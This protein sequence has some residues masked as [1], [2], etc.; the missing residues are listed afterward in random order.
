MLVREVVVQ[1][2]T[3]ALLLASL[4]SHVMCPAVQ[5]PQ[6]QTSRI[7]HSRQALLALLVAVRPISLAPLRV[8][9]V[10]V[11]VAVLLVVLL[12]VLLLLLLQCR[13]CVVPRVDESRL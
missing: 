13:G 9:A 12:A 6:L 8:T 3:V 11:L 5:R 1:E 10:A 2:E 4:L 7:V